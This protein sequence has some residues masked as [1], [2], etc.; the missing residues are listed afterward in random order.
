[1][2]EGVSRD[3]LFE[4]AL[5]G[6]KNVDE[7]QGLE[8]VPEHDERHLSS[9][10]IA[11]YANL[12]A[13]TDDNEGLTAWFFGCMTAAYNLGRGIPVDQGLAD[14]FNDFVEGIDWDADIEDEE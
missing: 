12:F 11:F 9:I 6:V 1:M 7:W 10:A 2:F 8:N 3:D 13:A 5:L 14:T 4:A